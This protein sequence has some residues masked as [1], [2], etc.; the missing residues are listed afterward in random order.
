MLFEENMTKENSKEGNQFMAKYKLSM[1]STCEDIGIR[2]NLFVECPEDTVVQNSKQKALDLIW[3][4]F[5]LIKMHRLNGEDNDQPPNTLV[6]YRHSF[7]KGYLRFR[8]SA[9]ISVPE[10]YSIYLKKNN[11][12]YMD[13][14]HECMLAFTKAV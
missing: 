12:E 7:K 1:N 3:S 11:A 13:K 5:G 10:K 2:M 9:K 14:L 4:V 6:Q 8:L